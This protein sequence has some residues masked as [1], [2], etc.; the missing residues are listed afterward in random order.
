MYDPVASELLMSLGHERKLMRA[1]G[2]TF[3]LDHLFRRILLGLRVVEFESE[4]I[5]HHLVD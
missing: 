4:I 1:I 5:T 3:T 2:A